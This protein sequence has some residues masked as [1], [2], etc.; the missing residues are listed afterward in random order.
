MA[1]PLDICLNRLFDDDDSPLPS[2]PVLSKIMNAVVSQPDNARVR[3]LNADKVLPLLTDPD[4][5]AWYVLRHA[6]FAKEGSRIILPDVDKANDQIKQVFQVFTEYVAMREAK[7]KAK[8]AAD[9]EME[10]RIAQRRAEREAKLAEEKAAREAALAA[11]K[12]EEEFV[13]AEADRRLAAWREAQQAEKLAEQAKRREARRQRREAILS[14]KAKLQEEAAAGSTS[15]GDS[16]SATTDPADSTILDSDAM[17]IA[18]VTA[19][20]AAGDGAEPKPT[21]A[22]LD[23][24]LAALEDTP[25]EDEETNKLRE[26]LRKM[27]DAELDEFEADTLGIST[28]KTE[29]LDEEELAAMGIR[30]KSKTSTKRPDEKPLSEMTYE[31]K[32]QWL[33]RRK[34]EN[35]IRK[36]K[37]AIQ[38]MKDAE[39]QRR[40]LGRVAMELQ[41]QLEEQRRRDA[42][43]ARRKEDAEK[44]AAAARARQLAKEDQERRKREAEERQKELE[45]IRAEKEAAAR[46]TGRK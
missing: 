33:E 35:R 38:K 44:R 37:E 22:D 27:T 16:V 42:M 46:A 3:N 26:K 12:A 4:L 41:E 20:P 18:P 11:Q 9:A 10:A 15:G 23:A 45:R 28:V 13:Q 19:A 43:A 2:V 30:P 39:K 32:M 17:T 8:M 24:E 31:E 29:D 36:E 1:V 25:D 14:L 5:A 40:E 21:V 7:Q 6:G 34:E